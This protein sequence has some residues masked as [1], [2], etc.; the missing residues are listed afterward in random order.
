LVVTVVA[1]QAQVP[2]LGTESAPG[3][4]VNARKSTAFMVGSSLMAQWNRASAVNFGRLGRRHDKI[5][6]P[7]A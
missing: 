5:P 2:P 6:F 7:Q 3:K 4:L 1:W